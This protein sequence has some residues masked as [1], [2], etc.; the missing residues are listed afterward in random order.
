[1]TSYQQNQ[2]QVI[3]EIEKQVN[4]N[5]LKFTL[6]P[7]VED[8]ENDNRICLTSVHIPSDNFKN[9]IQEKIDSLKKVSPQYYYYSNSS[10]HM[11][12]KNIRVINNPPHFTTNDIEIAKQIFLEII[13]K[14]NKFKVYFYRLLLFP[15]NLALIGTTDPELDSIVLDLDDRLRKEGIPDDKKYSNTRYFFSNMTLARFSAPSKEFIE[16]VKELSKQIQ[17]EPYIIDSVSLITCNAVLKNLQI[18]G[19]WNLA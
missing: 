6:V 3:N 16:K 7:P 9:N 17:L 10:L 1:M 13:P 14:H 8:Y 12:V 11:T 4:S 15:N 2:I 18:I 19:K 5:L